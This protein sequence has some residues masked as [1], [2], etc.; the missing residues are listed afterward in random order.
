MPDS[1][2]TH[3]NTGAATNLDLRA[4][5]FIGFDAGTGC[6]SKFQA[7]NPVDGNPIAQPIAPPTRR[8]WIVLWAL[9]QR[10][11]RFTAE[12]PGRRGRRS[13]VPSQTASRRST[14]NS[15]IAWCRRRLFPQRER[16]AK[17]DA[18]AISF[19]SSLT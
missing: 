15:L 1:G 3:G 11:F 7:I 19:A 12:R 9:P 14:N 10:R 6:E 17:W 2:P 8:T 18:P 5:S 13:S 16:A 4:R